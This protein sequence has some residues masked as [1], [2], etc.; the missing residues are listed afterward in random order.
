MAEF[1]P[2][3]FVEILGARD[4]LLRLHSVQRLALKPCVLSSTRKR[5]AKRAFAEEL[6]SS[7]LLLVR[8]IRSH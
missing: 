5:V 6:G 7:L 2:S 1:I 3:L 4:R 8:G